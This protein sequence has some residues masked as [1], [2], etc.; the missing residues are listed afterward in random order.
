MRVVDTDERGRVFLRMAAIAA[1]GLAA[2]FILAGLRPHTTQI[3]T[4]DRHVH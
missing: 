4:G 2:G 3:G 1:L